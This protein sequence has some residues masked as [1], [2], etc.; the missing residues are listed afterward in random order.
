MDSAKLYDFL[1]QAQKR[2]APLVLTFDDGDKYALDNVDLGFSIADREGLR[3]TEPLVV[4]FDDCV[5]ESNK[6]LQANADGKLKTPGVYWTS[7]EPA[8]PV[9]MEYTIEN[10]VTVW[11]TDKDYVVYDRNV[12]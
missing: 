11:D 1:L 7:T 9:N 4:A 3:E 12:N 10:V 6:R 2:N 8:Y 5:N